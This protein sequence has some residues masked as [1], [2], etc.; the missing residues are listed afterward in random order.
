VTISGL[1]EGQ[2]EPPEKPLEKHLIDRGA[3]LCAL[4][5]V[6]LS[7]GLFQ[8]LGDVG[9]GVADEGYLWYGTVHTAQ[10]EVPMRDFQAYDPGRYY[11]CAAW[12]FL[13][14]PGIVALRLS[15]SIFGAIGL[16]FGL[17][18]C[19]RLVTRWWLLPPMGVVLATWMFPRHKYFE[20]AIAMMAVYLAVRLFESRRPRMHALCGVFIGGAGFIGRNH[21]AYTVVIFG[22][23]LLYLHWRYRE[24]SLLRKL[25]AMAGGIVLGYS[26]MLV[27]WAVVPGFFSAFVD[28]IRTIVKQGTNLPKE[29]PW[30]WA[31]DYAGLGFREGIETAS[32]GIAFLV[33]AVVIPLGLLVLLRMGR[34][35]S[36]ARVVLVC[37]AVVGAVYAHHAA[38]RSDPRHIAQCI[39]PAL[40]ALFAL[41]AAFPR[42]IAHR[43][44]W[45]A[46]PLFFVASFFTITTK[47]IT[48]ADLPI[49]GYD[50]PMVSLELAGEE[51]RLP[52]GTAR[53][54][55]RVRQP[56]LRHVAEDEAIFIAPY[57]PDFYP[58]LGKTSPTWGIY[59]YWPNAS[60]E[61]QEE[62]IADF[63]E[64]GMN[65][66]LLSGAAIDGRADLS[67]RVAY[68]LVW[69]YFRREF[70]LVRVPELPPGYTLLRRRDG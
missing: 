33:P 8:L 26:P 55:E 44:S 24:G 41:P 39:H 36:K 14:G 46:W 56:V 48:L 43:V 30:P 10:G 58:M 65:W 21:A 38:V 62:M 15:C 50:G 49:G 53:F 63:E 7:G 11:W 31:L 20:H 17:L 42:G 64:K 69:E 68:G 29:W 40:L 67:F 70:A 25:S 9:F 23:L 28:S 27:M 47:D 4:L 51:L 66:A 12:S 52:E 45:S 19:R 59:F 22:V 5:A 2:A 13:F 61:E 6:V 54:I 32:V 16:F 35:S 37:A 1:K 60:R 57:H 34:A 18:V 3:V